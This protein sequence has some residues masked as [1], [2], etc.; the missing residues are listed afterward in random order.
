MCTMKCGITNECF[1]NEEDEDMTR[2]WYEAG[3]EG[4]ASSFLGEDGDRFTDCEHWLKM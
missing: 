1:E 4:L 2:C 3:L